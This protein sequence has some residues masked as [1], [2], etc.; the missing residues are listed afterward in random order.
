M[1]QP[2]KERDMPHEETSRASPKRVAHVVDTIRRP[3]LFVCA[4]GFLKVA[5][6]TRFDPLPATLLNFGTLFRLQEIPD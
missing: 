5:L 1:L 2:R 4:F 3:S 6:I